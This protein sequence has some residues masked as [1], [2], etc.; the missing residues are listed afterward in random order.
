MNIEIHTL[1]ETVDTPKRRMAS[2]TETTFEEAI[3][4][5]EDY[6][7]SRVKEIRSATGLIIELV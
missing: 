2:L 4:M 5:R 3:F 1:K 7:K 6:S